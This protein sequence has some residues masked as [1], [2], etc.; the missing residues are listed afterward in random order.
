MARLGRS[1]PL[2]R[3]LNP[4]K[5]APQ[6]GHPTSDVAVGSWTTAPLW[7]KIDEGQPDASDEIT[8]ETLI[9]PGNTSIAKIG[10]GVLIDPEVG[11][12]HVLR[13]QAK[14]T[15]TL[16]L[17]GGLRAE[18]REGG[19]LRATLT[20]DALTASYV[21]YVYSLSVA[22]GNAIVSYATLEI[23]LYGVFP[24]GSLGGVQVDWL[25]FEVPARVFGPQIYDLVIDGSITPVGNLIRVPS[26]VLA[27]SITPSGA[28]V[29]Q[30]NTSYAGGVSPS[31]SLARQANK[32]YTGGVTPAGAISRVVAKVPSGSITPSGDP[33]FTG[34]R[35]FSGQITPAGALTKLVSKLL[36]GTLSSSGALTKK[37][38]LAFTGAVTPSG[39]PDINVSRALG[40]TITPSGSIVSVLAKAIGGTITPAGSVRWQANKALSGATVPSGALGKTVTK[41]FAGATTPSGVLSK[42]AAKVFSGIIAFSGALT[43]VVI[44]VVAQIPGK[45]FASIDRTRTFLG[46]TKAHTETSEDVGSST[47]SQESGRTISWVDPPSTRTD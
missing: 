6:H 23:W 35:A 46:I 34:V 20:T 26:K 17:N 47:G 1:F 4:P 22:E 14:V 25:E 11:W 7:S 40:G 44:A 5:Y 9:S 21:T 16:G 10:L 43:N 2:N 13:V 29:R 45:V 31:G 24:V 37:I 39:D 27:G 32:T 18:L 15:F 19:I 42:V 36:S 33:D 8:S 30:A 41:S 12:G 38:N 28:L 3:S